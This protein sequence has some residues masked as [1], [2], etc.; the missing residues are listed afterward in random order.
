MTH[1]SALDN[2]TAIIYAVL[3]PLRQDMTVIT[4]QQLTL[5]L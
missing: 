4:T 5:V 3:T 1:E 2:K